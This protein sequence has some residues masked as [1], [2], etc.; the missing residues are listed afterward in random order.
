MADP[1]G[2]GAG[3]WQVDPPTAHGLDGAKLRG[4]WGEL[5]SHASLGRDCLV[6]IKDGALVFE[7]YASADTPR[8]SGGFNASSAH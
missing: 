1:L 8:G 4:A 2:P 7:A 5:S 3:P 6:I